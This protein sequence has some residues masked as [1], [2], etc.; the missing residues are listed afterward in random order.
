LLP[1]NGAVDVDTVGPTL[2]IGG[3]V[4]TPRTAMCTSST[5]R[6]GRPVAT[7]SRYGVGHVS[8]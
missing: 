3:T 1:T 6:N 5:W 4:S 7:T 2:W 8:R